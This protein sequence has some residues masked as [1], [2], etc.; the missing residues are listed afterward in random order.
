MGYTEYGLSG[1]AL[2]AWT[3]IGSPPTWLGIG[4][5][6]GTEAITRSGLFSE[7]SAQRVQY[8]VRNG[9]TAGQVE[10]TY[11]K[12]STSLSGLTL[13]NFGMFNTSTGGTIWDIHTLGSIAFDGTVE[14]QFSIK[15]KMV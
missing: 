7:Y 13:T 3:G 6:S 5:G 9:S 4:S 1:A 15:G 8:T 10:W 12:G 14:V 2:I 11:D